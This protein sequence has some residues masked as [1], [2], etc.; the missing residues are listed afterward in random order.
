MKDPPKKFYR[1]AVGREVRLRYACLFTC[2]HVVED[3]AGRLLEI[4]GTMDPAS[5][6][7][8]APDGRAV[9]GTIHWV[10]ARNAVEIPVRLYDRLFTV[11]NPLADDARDFTAFLNPDSAR[12]AVALA[13]PSVAALPPGSHVQFERMGYFFADPADSKPGAPVFNRTASLR[14]SW[15]KTSS[16]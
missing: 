15:A 7:G 12:D 10:S 2:T 14:D 11:E 1:L 13:E 16:K 3:D 5:R 4:H 9:R 6:G 8:T